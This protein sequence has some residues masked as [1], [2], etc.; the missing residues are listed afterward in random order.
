MGA[1]KMHEPESTASLLRRAADEIEQ[2]RALLAISE[3]DCARLRA[4]VLELAPK[5][6]FQKKAEAECDILLCFRCKHRCPHVECS[7][8][9]SC[10]NCGPPILVPNDK[11]HCTYAGKLGCKYCDRERESL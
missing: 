7:G 3:Q 6:V 9:Y 11:E 2:L 10:P 1:T 8:I 5:A 4:T